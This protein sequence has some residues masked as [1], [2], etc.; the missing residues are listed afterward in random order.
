MTVNVGAG[1]NSVKWTNNFMCWSDTVVSGSRMFKGKE[2]FHEHNIR[3]LS[4]KGNKS[5]VISIHHMVSFFTWLYFVTKLIYPTGTAGNP[6]WASVRPDADHYPC[7]VI[8]SE[9]ELQLYVVSSK[10]IV[11]PKVNFT[12]NKAGSTNI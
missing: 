4:S 10:I 6:R 5:I 7:W 12:Y 2:T 9:I 11:N 8:T 3:C 1:L